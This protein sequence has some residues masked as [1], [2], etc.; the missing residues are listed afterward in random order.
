MNQ[1]FDVDMKDIL[2]KTPTLVE[3][4]QEE[5]A[6]IENAIASLKEVVTQQDIDRLE[7]GTSLINTFNFAVQVQAG[8]VQW[9]AS[10][11]RSFLIALCA[12]DS[13]GKTP[14]GLPKERPHGND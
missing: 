4:R 14:T 13:I 8:R 3:Q 9:Q 5:P 11:Y 1:D 6:P 7:A 12:M 10:D 2:N